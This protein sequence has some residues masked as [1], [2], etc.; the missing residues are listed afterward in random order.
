MGV[1]CVASMLRSVLAKKG[2]AKGNAASVTRSSLLFSSLL[3]SKEYCLADCLKCEDF[4]KAWDLWVKHRWE[5]K[6][7]LT[8]TSVFQQLTEFGEWGCKRSVA[9]IRHT[10]KK[11]WQGIR[12]PDN[13]QGGLFDQAKDTRTAKELLGDD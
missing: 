13:G 2:N 10:I 1:A 9:A 12:E 4:G 8:P 3:S 5:K 6:A 7:P 11:G